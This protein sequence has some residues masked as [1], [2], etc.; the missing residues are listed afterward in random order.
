MK[1]FVKGKD[2]KDWKE[3]GFEIDDDVEKDDAI[4]FMMRFARLKVE[5]G[6]DVK[7]E[8]N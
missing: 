3:V 1:L 2:I 6:Y 5:Q 8:Q 4:Y 7:I